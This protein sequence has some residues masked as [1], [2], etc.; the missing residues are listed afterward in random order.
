[1][2]KKTERIIMLILL[3]VLVIPLSAPSVSACTGI[4]LEGQDGT[5]VYGRTMEWSQFDLHSQLVVYPRETEFQGTTPEGKN[6]IS[7]T[8]E[9][10]FLAI[11]L[12][13]RASDDGMNEVGLAG[14][15]FY[16]TGFAEYSEYDPS[17][18]DQS[19]APTDVLP[20]I[21]SNFSSI[22]EVKEGMKEVE[23]ISVVDPTLNKAVPFHLMIAEPDGDSLVIEFTNGE[24][25]FFDNPVG[26]ITNNPTFDWH[27]QNLRNYGKLSVEPYEEKTWGEQEITPLASGSGLLGLPGDFTSPSRFVRAALLKEVAMKTTGGMETVN[28]FFRIMD[29]FNVPNSQGEGTKGEE[30][31]ER[32]PSDT[33]WTVGHDMDNL[34]TYYHTMYNRRVRKVELSEI[35]FGKSGVRKVALDEEKEQNVKDVT[36]KLD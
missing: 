5:T 3:A 26:V 2:N 1:M 29:S 31:S 34:V 10:G 8:A 18:A 16:H 33:Q 11:E 7:W 22:S 30:D 23:V 15:A 25:K 21:L 20:Y 36:G 9:Y 14:G 28:E 6:G 12:M 4:V 17:L 13:G 27:L 35:D 32:M 24:I 19:L